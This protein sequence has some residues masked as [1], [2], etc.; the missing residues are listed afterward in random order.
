MNPND[1]RPLVN[2]A[3]LLPSKEERRLNHKATATGKYW[4]QINMV[5]AKGTWIDLNFWSIEWNTDHT[6]ALSKRK[7]CPD[8]YY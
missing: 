3:N 4:S 8:D 7:L 1:L 6:S 2:K 5:V